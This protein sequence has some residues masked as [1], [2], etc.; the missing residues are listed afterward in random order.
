[1]ETIYIEDEGTEIDLDCAVD[2]SAATA[3]TIQVL[4]ADG[5]ELV[6]AATINGTTGIKYTVPPGVFDVAGIW[7]MQAL[8]TLPS[9]KWRGE[10]V[11]FMVQRKYH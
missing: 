10:T 2:I 5:V 3:Q 11:S 1:M 9:G 4:K 8:I 7:K 6:W